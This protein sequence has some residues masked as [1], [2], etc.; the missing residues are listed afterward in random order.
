MMA[1]LGVNE[2]SSVDHIEQILPSVAQIDF[3]DEDLRSRYG[4]ISSEVILEEKLIGPG[5]SIE[6]V[7][8]EGQTQVLGYNRK[9]TDR[10]YD[11]GNILN[12]SDLS[13]SF[14]AMIDQKMDQVHR[15]LKVQFGITHVELRMVNNVP[16]ILE[17]NFRLGGDYI[18]RMLHQPK[19]LHLG[20]LIANTYTGNRQPQLKRQLRTRKALY[21]CHK[22]SCRVLDE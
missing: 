17:V 7:T 10:F 4:D 12:P 2:V 21:F 3:L 16:K 11:L 15:A 19:I 14:R 20:E 1:S 18:P 13:E 6:C 5:Y 22:N 8:F 9:I